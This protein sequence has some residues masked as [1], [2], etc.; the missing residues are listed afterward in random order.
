[1]SGE[2]VA[3][4][5]LNA[6][7][8][9]CL[10]Y[11]FKRVFEC[12]RTCNAAYYD[13]DTFSLPCLKHPMD[14]I[15]LVGFSRGGF[16]VRCLAAFID[17]VGLL[18]RKGLAFLESLFEEWKNGKDITKSIDKLQTNGLL[19][20]T[21]IKVLA[22]SDTVSSIFSREF[23]FVGASVPSCVDSAFHAISIH[24]RRFGFDPMPYRTAGMRT[25][26]Q[27]CAFV[28][29]HS[30]IGGGSEDSGSSM[31]PFVWMISA[32]QSASKARLDKFVMFRYYMPLAIELQPT[33]GQWRSMLDWKTSKEPIANKGTFISSSESK[34]YLKCSHRGWWAVWKRVTPGRFVRPRYKYWCAFKKT[35]L[36]ENT[37]SPKRS[38]TQ[39]LCKIGSVLSLGYLQEPHV[40]KQHSIVEDVPREAKTDVGLTIHWTVRMLQERYKHSVGCL[41]GYKAQARDESVG[42]LILD[43]DEQGTR[44]SRYIWRKQHGSQHANT[45]VDGT[46]AYLEELEPSETEVMNYERWFK[47]GK[48]ID[49]DRSDEEEDEETSSNERWRNVMEEFVLKE[50]ITVPVQDRRGETMREW[51][52]LLRKEIEALSRDDVTEQIANDSTDDD[53]DDSPDNGTDHGTD[54]GTNDRLDE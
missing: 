23:S 37:G 29:C 13:K 7:Y 17:K 43:R 21:R 39:Y 51:F 14:E 52:L 46:G 30:D 25:T 36:V 9:L 3:G 16:T 10:N 40:V 22:E 8:F 54:H 50:D 42:P 45:P 6:Y 33:S 26:V 38:W 32:I 15:I 35:N 19:V 48:K 2:G 24:E 12:Q 53:T 11:N 20:R 28:V 47:Y 31:L 18:R 44:L 49:P 27:Q 41:P 4:H 1:M 5:I 34:G